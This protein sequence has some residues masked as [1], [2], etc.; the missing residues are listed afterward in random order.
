MLIVK[1]SSLPDSLTASRLLALHG[2]LHCSE[3]DAYQLIPQQPGPH[4]SPR[5]GR[6]E[7][8]MDGIGNFRRF[9]RAVAW[10]FGRKR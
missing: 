5:G 2:L 7:T 3:K 4:R 9:G 6:L 1:S 10:N 8:E